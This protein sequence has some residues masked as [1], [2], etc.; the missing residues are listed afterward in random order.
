M[1]IVI[2]AGGSGT[3]LWPISRQ[4]KPKHFLPLLGSRSL[5]E[6]K[7]DELRP[8]LNRWSDLYISVSRPFVPLV[9]KLVPRLPEKNIIAE[10]CG[11][12]TGPAI[13]LETAIIE[14]AARGKDDP[15]IASLTV[16]DVFSEAGRF[17][18]ALRASEK[19][20]Q[21]H[22]LWIVAIA[23]SVKKPDPG[24]SY[25]ERGRTMT[26]YGGQAFSRSLRWIEKPSGV[27]LT[28]LF[29]NPNVYAHTGLYVWKASTIL[30]LFEKHEPNVYALSRRIQQYYG[31]AAFT[32][33]LQQ[34]FTAMPSLTIEEAVARKAKNIAVAAG[35]FGWSD[36]GKW[37]LVKDLI[38][39]GKNNVTRGRVVTVGTEDSLIYSPRGKVAGIV[40]VRGLIVVDTGDALLVCPKDR[41][42]D[43]KTLVDRLKEYK[44]NRYL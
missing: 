23:S 7:V 40:G 21:H 38:S 10:P 14:A 16:D 18:D 33:R 39:E 32:R 15:V 28:R 17:R 29:K 19:F 3:R 22:P 36:T 35:D 31:R 12:N 13:A 37:Y 11:R 43:V 34:Y 1:K 8:L 4:K 42:G 9:R 5:M 44:L 27:Q 25:I 20:L 26:R 30:S 41:S 24:L 2:R 6:E